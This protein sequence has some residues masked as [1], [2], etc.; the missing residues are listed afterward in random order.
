MNHYTLCCRHESNKQNGVKTRKQNI[1]V[2]KA[3][4][5]KKNNTGIFAVNDS[6]PLQF[7]S[8]IGINFLHMGAS[9]RDCFQSNSLTPFLPLS[10]AFLYNPNAETTE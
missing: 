3:L 9:T 8:Y 10:G 7:Y 5:G 1:H 2:K 6:L 4:I